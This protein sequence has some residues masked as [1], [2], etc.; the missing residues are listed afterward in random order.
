M[1]LKQVKMLNTS[2]SVNKGEKISIC[3]RNKS[4]NFLL[5]KEIQLCLLLY[6]N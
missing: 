6:T 3:L 1:I 4:D 5:K 2:Y